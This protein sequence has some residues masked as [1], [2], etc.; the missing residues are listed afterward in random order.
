MQISCVTDIDFHSL[1]VVG[2]VPEQLIDINTG[3][4][5]GGGAVE[6]V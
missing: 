2:Q 1:D 5:T 4:G 3:S 6:T